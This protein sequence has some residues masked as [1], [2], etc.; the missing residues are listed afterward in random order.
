M[1]K[2]IQKSNAL[3]GRYYSLS[4]PCMTAG[5]TSFEFLFQAGIAPSVPGFFEAMDTSPA[6]ERGWK[7]NAAL[8]SSFYVE[9]N[10]IDRPSP[11]S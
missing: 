9:L 11:N 5:D 10:F 2:I 3:K 6:M 1:T 4:W 7:G 8:S